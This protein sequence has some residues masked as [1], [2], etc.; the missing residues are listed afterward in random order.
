MNHTSGLS[1]TSFVTG[2]INAT[3]RTK[4]IQTRITKYQTKF[5]QDSNISRER[6]KHV[7]NI[8]VPKCDTNDTKV[9]RKRSQNVTITIPKLY[10]N[11][12]K[13]IPSSYENHTKFI[14]NPSQHHPNIIRKSSE[15]HPKIIRKSSEIY[16]KSS[17][18]STPSVY[19]CVKL[20]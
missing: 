10:N 15:N 20:S 9:V 1:N 19:I 2:Q 8:K 6:L 16:Q 4:T 11:Y 18:N 3:K 13:M 12:F 5:K 7:P 17:D 14:R